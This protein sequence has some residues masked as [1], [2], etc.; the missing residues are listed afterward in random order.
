[1]Q[2]PPAPQRRGARFTV[3]RVAVRRHHG[4]RHSQRRHHHGHRHHHYHGLGRVVGVVVVRIVVGT[5]EQGAGR[6]LGM[7]GGVRVVHGE[8]DRGRRDVLVRRDIHRVREVL[9]RGQEQ[10]RVDRVAVHGR[11]AAVRA[12]R[13]LPNRPVRLPEGDHHR[14]RDRVRRLRHVRVR[15]LAVHIVHHV[16]PDIRVRA[17]PVLRGRRRHCRLL[18][19]QEAVS[20]HRAVRVRQRHR[21][22]HFRAAQSQAAQLLRLARVH[23]HTGRP[24]PQPVRV[25]HADEGPAL[26]QGEGPERVEEEETRAAAEAT[27]QVHGQLRSTFPAHSV[28]VVA[29]VRNQQGRN[30][31]IVPGR[32]R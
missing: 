10:D 9:R 13:Q 30:R 31:T 24:V 1:M 19:R 21:Y 11:A 15:R 5:A 26:D 25:R 22:V 17:V 7:G 2:T 32:I 27:A 6:R 8:H 20:G 4:H 23:A 3:R 12:D 14:I 28:A 18:L 16:R 29:H